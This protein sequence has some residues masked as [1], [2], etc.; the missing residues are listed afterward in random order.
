MTETYIQIGHVNF[1]SPGMAYHD[2]TE[3]LDFC[4]R[5]LSPKVSLHHHYERVDVAVFV[6]R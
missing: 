2:P 6:Y 5:S 1:T 4:I 3:V